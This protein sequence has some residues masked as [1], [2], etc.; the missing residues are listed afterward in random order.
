MKKIIVLIL[1]LLILSP[2][3]ACAQGINA[4]ELMRQS[5]YRDDGKDAYF[6]I[7]MVLIDKAGDSRVR[8]LEI[9]TKDFGELL[10][11]YIEFT[12]PADIEGTKFLS[13]ENA[14]GDDTQY[15][16]LP[17]L[18]RG[19]RIVSSQKNLRFVN[20]DFSYEDVQR[21]RPD[22]DN[23]RLLK[24]T[25]YSGLDCAVIESKPKESENSQYSKRITWL[26][27]KSLVAVKV[28][29]YNQRNELSKILKVNKLGQK[30]GI[31]TTLETRMEDLEENHETLMKIKEVT[32]N[33]GLSDDIFSLRKLEED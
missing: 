3:I 9:L 20:T 32:Y 11:T 23:H 5:F 27:K 10:K 15:L 17:E 31:W 13:L 12:A 2:R 6:K 8:E 21:R 16:Y 4:Q 30:S 19:R 7:E 33:Q 28:E 26:D 14:E 18:G 22:K 1:G 25:L 29:F 24:E